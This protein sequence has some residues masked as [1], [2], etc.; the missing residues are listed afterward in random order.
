MGE[1]TRRLH[2]WRAFRNKKE[3]HMRKRLSKLM[4]VAKKVQHRKNLSYANRY[5]R[6][7]LRNQKSRFAKKVAKLRARERKTKSQKRKVQKKSKRAVK[8]AVGFLGDVTE[9]RI[10]AKHFD[11]PRQLARELIRRSRRDRKPTNRAEDRE[12][13]SIAEMMASE[14]KFQK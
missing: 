5:L 6:A 1:A 4:K 11:A 7:Q 9:T 8:E 3:D 2:T 13:A 10:V 14:E 12:E